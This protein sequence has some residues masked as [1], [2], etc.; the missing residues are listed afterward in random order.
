VSCI[1]WYRPARLKGE[2]GLGTHFSLKDGGNMFLS[3]VAK[4]LLHMVKLTPTRIK[5]NTSN[6]VELQDAT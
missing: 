2:G 1:G 6:V 4:A 5:V 3:N